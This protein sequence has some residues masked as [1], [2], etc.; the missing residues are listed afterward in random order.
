MAAPRISVAEGV[1]QLA[2]GE[3]VN[4]DRETDV[5]VVGFG[6]AGACAAIEARA[7]GADVLVIDRFDGG[8]ATAYSGGI[9]YA[10][11]T[12]VQDRLGVKDDVATMRAYLETELGDAI[13]PE[14]LQRFCEESRADVDWLMGLGMPYGGGL[15]TAKAHYPTMTSSLYYSG[16]EKQLEQAAGVKAAARGH[17]ALGDGYTGHA[18]YKVLREAAL[19]NG[20]QLLA[21]APVTRL[22]LD[23]N[24]AVVG[25][26]ARP[27]APGE[28]G[29]HQKLYNAVSPHR[30]LNAAGQDRTIARIRE[31]ES[32]RS[33]EPL[34]IR[35]RKG[36]IVSTGGYVFNREKLAQHRPD[37]ARHLRGIVRLGAVSD[38]GSGIELGQAAGGAVKMIDNV[39]LNRSIAPPLSLVYGIAVNAKGERF[40]NEDAYTGHLGAAISKQ[41]GGTAWLILDRSK[42][43]AAMAQTARPR[44]WT[45]FKVLY[46]PN[47]LNILGG[48]TRFAMSLR[49]LARRIGVPYDALEASVAQNNAAAATGKD[50]MGKLTETLKP[51]EGGP[52]VAI[53]L[54]LGNRYS[55]SKLFTLSGLAVSEETGGVLREDGQPLPGL[56]AAGR[57]AAGLCAVGYI[58]GMS[59]SDC[60]FSGRRAGRCA[61]SAQSPAAEAAARAG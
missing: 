57:A 60:V 15:F 52:Y 56:Y 6:G 38:D 14:T 43:I 31:L 33:A 37:L 48:G 19:R 59:L 9:V 46:A 16:N 11:N 21:H 26:E 41:P 40:L 17:R 35:A 28:V 8:G 12:A 20:A 39:F 22:I 36:V 53:S 49:K 18:F 27:V 55:F 5:I 10:G 47:L 32:T 42:F 4:W 61:A 50:P 24:G 3:T 1:R 25:V 23:A 45:E 29:R 34:L 30:P 58:S 44:R 13:S 54:A 51:I 7:A 2:P